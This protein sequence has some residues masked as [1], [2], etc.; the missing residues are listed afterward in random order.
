MR[1]SRAALF[2]ARLSLS[3]LV[4]AISSASCKQPVALPDSDAPMPCASDRDCPGLA[5]GPCSTGASVTYR[6][7]YQECVVNPCTV[8]RPT[9]R[10]AGATAVCGV[11]H[12]CVV[13]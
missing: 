5:C 9:D 8:N 4:I 11:T 10:G 3:S 12:T 7:Q 6:A 1:S 13:R 2:V